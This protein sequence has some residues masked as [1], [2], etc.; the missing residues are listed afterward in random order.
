MSKIAIIG[1]GSWGMALSVHLEKNG[2]NISVWSFSQE[3][4]DL[5]NNERT[6]KFLP[7]ILIS[8]NIYCST[9]FDEVLKDSEIVLIVT[10]SKFVRDTVVKFKQY[11]TNQMIIMCSK[12]LEDNSLITLTDVIKEEIPNAK[13]GALSGPSHAEEV[14]RG[15]PTAIVIASENDE[16][17]NKLQDLFVSDVFRVYT[18]KDLQGV[19]IGGALKNIIALC[20]GIAAGLGYGDNTFAALITRGLVEISRLGVEMGANNATFYGL[21]G[22][23]DLIVTCL[24]Q[25]SRNRRAGFLIGQGKTME[26][27]VKE[28]G[29]V[30][31]SIDNI[32]IAYKLMQK[33][34][35]E[36]PIVN[37]VYDVLFNNLPVNEGVK[38]LMTRG[39]KEE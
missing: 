8:E 37:T 28:V 4:A 20:T 35:V 1:S 30:V 3:E 14:A 12:G 24:S 34:N 10:P 6:C 27:A 33:Y 2:H 17:L 25:H 29:M 22:L 7:E 16:V 21:T 31:E 9:N 19:E 18:S 26:E 39:K 5:I 13:I 32:K 36:M 23:G 11:I 15:I 38:S